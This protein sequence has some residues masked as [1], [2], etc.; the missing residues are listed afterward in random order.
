MIRYLYLL[1]FFSTSLLTAQIQSAGNG[2]WP[3]SNI[4]YVSTINAQAPADSGYL[5]YN[6]W[7]FQDSKGGIHNFTG[8]LTSS[9]G[10]YTEY[11]KNQRPI[12]HNPGYT[13][14]EGKSDDGQWYIKIRGNSATVQLIGTEY[15]KYKVLSVIYTP[16]GVNSNVVYEAG[17]TSGAVS[18]ITNTFSNAISLAFTLGNTFSQSWTQNQTN[19]NSFSLTHTATSSDTDTNSAEGINHDNDFIQVWLNPAVTTY[20]NF[21]AP[22][23][24]SI[25]NNP[26]DPLTTQIGMDFVTV[27]VG[28][29][30]GTQPMSPQLIQAFQRSW[31]GPNAGLNAQDFANIVAA[32]PYW[33]FGSSTSIFIP[34]PRRFSVATGSSLINYMPQSGSGSLSHTYHVSNVGSN[35]STI[36]YSYSYSSAIQSS[37]N[38]TSYLGFSLSDTVTW[39]DTASQETIKTNTMN[40]TLNIFPPSSTYTG[41]GAVITYVDN[42]YGT[43]LFVYANP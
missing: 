7:K 28:Q 22:A 4:T 17:T 8:K 1:I 26:A 24:Y 38:F 14:W 18:T 33:N 3:G 10:D 31:D 19:T 37:Y 12:H 43:F 25:N 40:A 15:P 39:T 11:P 32:D 42:L 6:Q 20:F 5:F 35:S 23:T 34:D 9:W 29:L 21:N 2:G 36:S 30:K 41:P 13:T 16:P 27:T